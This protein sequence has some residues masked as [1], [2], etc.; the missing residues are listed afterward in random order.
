[1][2]NDNRITVYY[3]GKPLHPLSN[4]KNSNQSIKEQI[5]PIKSNKSIGLCPYMLPVSQVAS[6]LS[7]KKI[8]MFAYL[9]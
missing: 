3:S 9:H 6:I 4:D 5:N 1:M 7:L 8:G 2:N